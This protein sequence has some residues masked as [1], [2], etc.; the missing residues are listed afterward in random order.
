MINFKFEI[1]FDNE[2]NKIIDIRDEDLDDAK[3]R[4]DAVA[5]A[6]NNSGRSCEWVLVRQGLL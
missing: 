3:A 6:Y 1:Q 5:E 2:P 4:I